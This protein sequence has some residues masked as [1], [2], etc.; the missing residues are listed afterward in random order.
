LFGQ[1]FTL[2]ECRTNWGEHRVYFTDNQGHVQSIS[3]SYT[4]VA[5]VDP[6]VEIAAGRSYF[7]FDD[8]VR[9]VV[10]LDRLQ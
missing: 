4:S 6:F 3:A 9:L 2:V 8:L 5:A 7:R 10:L 1:T